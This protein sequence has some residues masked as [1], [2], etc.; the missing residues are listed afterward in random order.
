MKKF[1]SYIR[2]GALAVALTSCSNLE[3]VGKFSKASAEV[4]KNTA[5]AKGI[6]GSTQRIQDFR[7]GPQ[8][9]AGDV[10]AKLV[11]RAETSGKRLIAAQKVLEDYFNSLGALSAGDLTS[12][13]KEF[14]GFEKALKGSQWATAGEAEAIRKVAEAVTSLATDIYRRKALASIIQKSNPVIQKIAKEQTR[15]LDIYDILLNTEEAIIALA[16]KEMTAEEEV[17]Q[18]RSFYR[19]LVNDFNSR[20]RVVVEN[21]R[22]KG[23][24][25]RKALAE[26]A[27]GHEELTVDSRQ[28]TLEE[29]KALIDQ[30]SER[31]KAA[32]EVLSA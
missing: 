30:H 22:K 11:K 9:A 21:E 19:T 5:V 1:L 14:E 16:V 8:P 2:L 10:S 20:T 26:V 15:I 32:Y 3:H 13:K 23:S 24:A 17:T 4:M 25:F 29:L 28:L 7:D 12:F 31:I 6:A 27:K 18:K